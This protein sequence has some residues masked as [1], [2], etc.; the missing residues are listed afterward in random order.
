M[1]QGI[2]LIYYCYRAPAI[3]AFVT[4]FNFFSYD[5]VVAEIRTHPLPDNERMRDILYHSRGQSK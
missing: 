4:I 1:D 5:A 3:V 2:T